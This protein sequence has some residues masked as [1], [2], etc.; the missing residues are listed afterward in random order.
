MA[1]YL[2]PT[3]RGYGGDMDVLFM[4]MYGG[5]SYADSQQRQLSFCPVKWPIIFFLLD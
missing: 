4:I 3:T 1:L 2:I 5:D